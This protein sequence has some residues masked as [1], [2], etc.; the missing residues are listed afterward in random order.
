MGVCPLQLPCRIGEFH[1]SEPQSYNINLKTLSLLTLTHLKYN[2]S[3]SS[4]TLRPATEADLPAIQS[5]QNYWATNTYL[6]LSGDSAV[7]L[8]PVQSEFNA[9][10]IEGLPFF[11]AVATPDA[12]A[13]A[14]AEPPQ[15]ISSSSVAVP[16]PGRP[17]YHFTEPLPPPTLAYALLRPFRPEEKAFGS[18]VELLANAHPLCTRWMVMQA[19]A[20]KV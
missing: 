16:A 14:A 15:E 20:P 10:Q 8:E 17:G 4:F 9:S 19:I 13:E 18:T 5:I 3:S 2:M 1:Y 7:P 6:Q 11:V 12:A